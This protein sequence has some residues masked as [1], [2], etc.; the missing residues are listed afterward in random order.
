VFLAGRSEWNYVRTVL[1]VL[2]RSIPETMSNTGKD[3]LHNNHLS[4]VDGDHV[5][6]R[7]GSG[8][9]AGIQ[10]HDL[11]DKLDGSPSRNS[12]PMSPAQRS[13]HDE[14]KGLPVSSEGAKEPTVVTDTEHDP[15]IVDWDGEHDPEKPFNWGAKKKWYAVLPPN[16]I[17]RTDFNSSG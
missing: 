5:T 4:S 11:L 10:H 15:T 8:E 13:L 7:V 14:E 12:S 6:T 17:Y 16:P 2:P 9:K 3:E 1:T